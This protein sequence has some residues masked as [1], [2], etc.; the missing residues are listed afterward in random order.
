MVWQPLSLNQQRLETGVQT[1]KLVGAKRVLDLGC[2]EGQL[3]QK[4]L[5]EREFT[6]IVGVDVDYRCLEIA[7]KRLKLDSLAPNQH[8]IKLLQG[9][10]TYTDKRLF[11]YDAAALIEVIEHLD[12]FRLSTFEQVLFKFTRPKT[13][14]ITTPNVEYNVNFLF[15]PHGQLRHPDHRFEWTRQEFQSWGNR[16]AREYTYQVQF[17]PIG[18]ED[19]H[20]GAP[21]Q[22][23]VF[24]LAE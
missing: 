20:L 8:R 9:S 15:F 2:G 12:Q 7:C 19:P 4:L 23:A 3:I 21:T 6:E 18:E 1:F 17:S 13:V 24:Q 14:I 22:M 16:V 5:P 10:L 11:G